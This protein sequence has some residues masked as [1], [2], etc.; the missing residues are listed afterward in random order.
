MTCEW[1]VEWVVSGWRVSDVRVAST[2]YGR[3]NCG[4]ILRSL[5]INQH[6]GVVPA[7]LTSYSS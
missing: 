3:N 4:V 5:S 6:T 1:R 7:E 2:V